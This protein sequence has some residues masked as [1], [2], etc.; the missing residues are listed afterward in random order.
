[1]EPCL[2]QIWDGGGFKNMRA[3]QQFASLHHTVSAATTF[4]ISHTPF[5]SLI[6]VN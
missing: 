3:V 1:M 6:V 4:T 5:T 2:G